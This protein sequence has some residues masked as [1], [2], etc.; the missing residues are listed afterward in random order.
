M[1]TESS[2]PSTPP[3]PP[4]D[5]PSGPPQSGPRPP[6]QGRPGGGGGSR[7]PYQGRPGGGGG[8]RRPRGRFFP[9]RRRI[10][11]CVE[12]QKIDY[13]DIDFLRRFLTDQAKVESRRKTGMCAKCQ[14]PLARAVK[15]ARYLAM[16]PYT[17][18]HR[19]GRARSFS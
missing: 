13:K 1:T 19:T 9:R 4:Q 18:H 8:P 14:R 6:Y 5:R 10:C 17:R 7:P 2:G 11:P 3:G 12:G 16:L 15:R